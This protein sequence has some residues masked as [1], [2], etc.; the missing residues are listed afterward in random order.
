MCLTLFSC[1]HYHFNINKMFYE[2]IICLNISISPKTH[3][4]TYQNIY[5]Y[6]PNSTFKNS[7]N[8]CICKYKIID[9][10]WNVLSL[11]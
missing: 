3:K 9:L 1:L 7:E 11:K 10:I 6:I 2:L 5:E 8:S 4:T